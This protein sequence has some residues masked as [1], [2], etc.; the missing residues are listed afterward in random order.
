MIEPRFA[1]GRPSPRA[2][3]AAGAMALG[4]VVLALGAWFASPEGTT[5]AQTAATP[6]PCPPATPA[7]GETASD[8][9]LLVGEYDIY[10]KPN[11]ITI[12]A[13]TAVRVVTSNRGEATHNF[14]VTDHENPDVE[15]LDISITTESG[16]EGETTINAPE[17]T[18]YF[19]CDQPGHEGA[20]MRGYLTVKADAEITTAEATVTPPVG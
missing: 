2:T 3:L 5:A 16:E 13:D 19:F 11:V 7:S 9:C 8:F 20:G 6:E 10:Y 14:S 1:A 18:Y 17:G 12:P 4:L 15:N